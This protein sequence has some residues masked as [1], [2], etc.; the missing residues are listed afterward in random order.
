MDG[1]IPLEM[2][3]PVREPEMEA[4]EMSEVTES[5][6]ILTSWKSVFK[7][8]Y[9]LVGNRAEAEDLTQEAFVVLFRE[10]KAGRPIERI[11][12]WMRTVTKHLAYRRYHQQRPDLHTSLDGLEE[13]VG[14]IP[15]ELLDPRPSPEKQIVDQSVLKLTAKVLSGF[16]EKDRECILMYLSGYSFQQ[17]G[18]ALGAPHWK[19]RKLTMKAYH[20]FQARMNRLQQ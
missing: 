12:A 17:I 16:S 6:P 18:S 11:N 8:A 9:S 13:E 7:H 14:H 3:L 2:N 5:N 15:S 1:N 20:L 4:E 10:Q 19:A